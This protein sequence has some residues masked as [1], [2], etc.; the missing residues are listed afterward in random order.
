[1]SS[2]TG[3]GAFTGGLLSVAMRWTD[4]LIGFGSTLVLARL[5]TPADFGLV[6][7]AMVVVGLVD[8]LLDLGVHAALIQNKSA[9]RHD[10]D[11]A[12]TL[13]VCQ[14]SIVA[15]VLALGAPLVAQYY[16]DLRVTD[17]MR[18]IALSVLIG[19]LENIGIV[20]FQKNME[21]DRDF[22]FFFIKRC[23][24]TVV[25]IVLAFTLRSYWALVLGSVAG[26]LVGVFLSYSMHSF[27]PRWSLSRLAGIWSFSQWNIVMNI[28]G[29]LNGRLDRLV[30]G[31]R[32][33]AA[34]VGTYTLAD[35]ISSM[36]T[37]DLL[38][39]LGRVMFPAFVDARE[40]PEEFGRI[41][42]LAFGIQALVGIPAG[43]GLLL[44]DQWHGAV[45]LVQWLALTGVFMAMVHSNHYMLLALGRIRTLA[46][47]YCIR[48]ALLLGLL[49][50]AFPNADAEGVAQV[51]LLVAAFGLLVMG[52]LAKR[53]FPQLQLWGMIR[54]A[55]RPIVA[56]LVMAAAVLSLHATAHFVSPIA[57]LMCKIVAGTIAYCATVVA[58]WWLSGRPTGAESYL[59]EGIRRRR[60]V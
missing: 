45:R 12:W 34:A 22:R 37:T 46:A 57:A 52:Y 4:R 25:T 47:Y 35:E 16:Q 42:L 33:D 27:R 20:M 53:A 11:T 24:G 43:V 29:Y 17:V 60:A 30:I 39:P 7:M 49:L 13:R 2:S 19:G 9:D 36:P 15:V 38:A 58:L 32:Q 48:L 5:L 56:A 6:A 41:V 50:L 3:T 54:S 31:R 1:M 28:A 18:V 40:R 55:Y 44:G 59:L 10:F 51:R 21:F 14:A 23:L 26:R 8:V